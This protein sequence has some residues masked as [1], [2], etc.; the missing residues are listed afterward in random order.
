MVF[1]AVSG[2]GTDVYNTYAS[3]Q[4]YSEKVMAA[5][6]VTKRHHSHY[7][8]RI[9][10][11]WKKFGASEVMYKSVHVDWCNLRIIYQPTLH[12]PFT[13]PNQWEANHEQ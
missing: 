6:D 10:L 12:L 2:T 13:N 5:L 9:V 8:N 7:K 3:K 1:K 4:T 11:K